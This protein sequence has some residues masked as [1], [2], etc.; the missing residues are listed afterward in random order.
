MA[1]DIPKAARPVFGIGPAPDGSSMLVVGV[2][3]AGWEY[4]KD[5]KTLTLD[6][7]KFGYPLQVVVFG[8]RDLKTGYKVLEDRNKRA[9]IASL[10]VNEDAGIRDGAV[11][12]PGDLKNSVT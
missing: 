2:T 5:G 3:D 6:L 8:C 7:R 10:R 11:R 9:G 4:A 1:E 12:T